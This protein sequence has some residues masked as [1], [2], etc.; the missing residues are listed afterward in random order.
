MAK[1]AANYPAAIYPNYQEH[2]VG[3]DQA[4]Y[5]IT[6]KADVALTAIYA[7]AGN[8]NLTVIGAF[9]AWPTFGAIENQTT[10]EQLVF[11]KTSSDTL[12]II[13]RQFNGTALGAGAIGQNIRYIELTVPGK[14]INQMLAEI[15]AIET[16]LGINPHGSLTDLVTRLAVSLNNDGTLK[17]A[18]IDNRIC[19]GRLTL[20]TG[21]PVADTT[22]GTTVYFT[23][24]I[25]NRISIFDGTNWKFYNFTER[26]IAITGQ[27]NGIPCDIFIF[28]NS[29]TLTLELSAWSSAT[30]R[31][32][33]IVLQDGVYV[34]TGATTRRYLGTI[35]P[36]S[37]TTCNDDTL[38][39]GVWNYCN[40]VRR[41]VSKTD[42]TDTWTYTAASFH[43][44][45]AVATN[46]FTYVVGLAEDAIRATVTGV[47]SNSA[48]AASVS[49]GVGVDSTTVNSAQ[50]FGG[51]TPGAGLSLH[52]SAH[53]V[54]L[55][56]G[57]GV[58]NIAWLEQSVVAGTTTW[59]GDN[60]GALIQTGIVGE[61][62]A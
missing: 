39:R 53:Y 20:A 43:I 56:S 40:R 10:L 45:N 33:N 7:G 6:Q 54:G 19:D 18:T 58:H 35:L 4:N 28:D 57:V 26:S 21:N 36:T 23:P 30:T 59:M 62:M 1:P 55:P 17:S 25:G 38:K 3:K 22:G 60:G 42:T 24:Y 41:A 11:T 51:V 61:V 37:G 46:L 27:T 12:A 9:A 48:G 29:G 14:T 5:A 47:C 15:K 52:H 50:I 31:S 44:A 13:Q 8:F 49:V 16:T 32:T 2:G 34:K